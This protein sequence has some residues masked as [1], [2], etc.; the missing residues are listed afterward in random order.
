MRVDKSDIVK[1]IFELP[2][3]VESGL[4]ML[5]NDVRI[6]DH[7]SIDIIGVDSS[8]RLVL[9]QIGLDDNPQI[10]LDALGRFDWIVRNSEIVRRLYGPSDVDYLQNP[11]VFVMIPHLSELFL[12]ISSYFSPLDLDLFEYSYVPSL[13]GLVVQKVD[14]ERFRPAEGEKGA[15]T[16]VVKPLYS[17]LKEVLHETFRKIEI[18]EIGPVSLITSDDR[19]LARVSFAEDFL[20]LDMPPDGILEI[21]DESGLENVLSVLGTRAEKFG[22]TLKDNPRDSGSSLPSLTEQELEALGGVEEKKE[23]DAPYLAETETE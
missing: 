2:G 5:D 7:G 10:L 6:A 13:D 20:I 1:K 15:V 22:I 16:Q 23:P 21:K 9:V 18:L 12:R 19:I 4:K 14:R 8:K 3:E 17:R 11:K